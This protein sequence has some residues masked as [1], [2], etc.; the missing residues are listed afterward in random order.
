MKDLETI[1]NEFPF[2]SCLRHSDI[3]IICIVQNVDDKII[4]A[5]DLSEITESDMKQFLFF[6]ETWWFESNRKIPINIFIG[7][8]MKHF[9]YSLKTFSLK[10]TEVVFGPT[11]SLSDLLIKRVKRRYIELVRKVD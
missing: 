11:V 5:Y 10:E 6:G 2:I 8:E 9:R 1:K 3:D 4:T 7:K